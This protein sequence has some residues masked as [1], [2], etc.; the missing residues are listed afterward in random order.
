MDFFDNALDKAKEAFE[1]VTKK[2]EE[3]V[4]TQKQ[5]FNIAS[6]E[7]QCSKCFKSLGEIYYARL[8]DSSIEGDDEVKNLVKM[9]SEK[10]EE[11]AKLKEEIN[12]AK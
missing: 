1:I 10:K 8:L 5:K 9:I 12:S 4:T 2:T 11:I 7:N 3:V 6:L